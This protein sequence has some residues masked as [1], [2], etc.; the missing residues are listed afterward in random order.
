M[1][2]EQALKILDLKTVTEVKEI[3][4]N[5]RRLMRRVHPD[6]LTDGEVS[7]YKYSAHEINT[8]Y[9]YLIKD[10]QLPYAKKNTEVGRNKCWNAPINETAYIQREIYQYAEGSD[11]S[12]IGKFCVAEGKYYFTDDEEYELF[13][14]S[15]YNCSRKLLE[16]MPDHVTAACLPELAYLL[17]SQFINP[18]EILQ[19]LEIEDG[20]YYV[21]AMLELNRKGNPVCPGDV[22]IPGSIRSH[23]L[24]LNYRYGTECGYVS[25]SD[26]R[27]YH[28]LIPMFEQRSVQLKIRAS[29][30]N[31]KK[32][33]R[34][35]PIDLWIK[36]RP[37]NMG[38]MTVTINSR[39]E[40]MLRKCR[41]EMTQKEKTTSELT[42]QKDIR[43]NDL[44]KSR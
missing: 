44:E 4:T 17:S 28:V 34:S 26:D 40:T 21:P 9:E 10:I 35:I 25:F 39:I 7:G 20:V 14:L 11:G 32:K 8:A 43:V 36:E 22:F 16:D 29:G 38:Q 2:Y 42:D 1:D 24:Y 30:S 37:G 41:S 5:Y 13:L 12:R 27:L 31:V 6:V 23:K 3:R 19:K 33:G 18:E 15:I